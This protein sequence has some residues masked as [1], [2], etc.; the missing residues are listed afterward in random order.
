MLDISYEY[1]KRGNDF[2]GGEDLGFMMRPLQVRTAANLG[3]TIFKSAG[4]L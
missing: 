1:A 2:E 4:W 3:N